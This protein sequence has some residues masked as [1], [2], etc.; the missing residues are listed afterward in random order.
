MVDTGVKQAWLK[1][2]SRRSLVI[3]GDSRRAVDGTGSS[4]GAAGAGDRA[5]YGLRRSVT[6]TR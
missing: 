6:L 5:N 3:G 2:G 1:V 4:S